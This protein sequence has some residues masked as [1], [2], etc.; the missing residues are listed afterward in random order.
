MKNI[1]LACAY[2]HEDK[3]VRVQRF[4]KINQVAAL[5]MAEGYRVFSPISHGHYIS[6]FLTDCGNNFWL[7]QD[8]DF[9]FNWAG[10]VWVFTDEKNAWKKSEGVRVELDVAKNRGI[11]VRFISL[12]LDGET[13]TFKTWK[14]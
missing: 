8:L 9:V 3:E 2:Y 13:I 14:E 1:Y 6:E 10:E 4:K 7:N 12:D 11:P 5:V